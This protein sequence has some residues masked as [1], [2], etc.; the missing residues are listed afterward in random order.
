MDMGVA[1]AIA[2][3]IAAI[4]SV[5]SV[6]IGARNAQHSEMR[7][8]YR[9]ALTPYL[10]PM[11]RELNQVTACAVIVR[12]RYLLGQAVAAW[13][14]NGTAS[15]KRLEVLRR[16]TRYLLP[17]LITP[18]RTAVLL[19]Y[20][21]TTYKDLPDTNAEDLLVAGQKLSDALNHAIEVSYRKGK[22]VSKYRGYRLRTQAEAIDALWAARPA[23]P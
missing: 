8:A 3:I 16:D 9:Q 1:T 20:R 15:A 10:A 2:A 6:V 5:V 7:S 18:L 13:V 17:R 21:I 4:A 23:R 19:I 12:R 14:A 11:S 22:P